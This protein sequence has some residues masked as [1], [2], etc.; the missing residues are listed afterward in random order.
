MRDTEEISETIPGS[1]H[2]S[3][4]MVEFKADPTT[5]YHEAFFDREMAYVCYCVVGLRST[6]VT[7]RLA[8]MG[9]DIANLEGGIEAWKDAGGAVVSAGD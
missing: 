3:R 8:E 6:F 1:V 5:D 9:Y 2:T 4:G 7:D